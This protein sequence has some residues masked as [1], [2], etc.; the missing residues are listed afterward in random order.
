MRKGGDKPRP[1]T[2]IRRG[3]VYP[4]PCEFEFCKRLFHQNDDLA[5]IGT[6]FQLR[7]VNGELVQPGRRKLPSWSSVVPGEP[8]SIADP[9]IAELQFGSSTARRR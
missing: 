1:Y 3:G 8:H 7:D 2:E 5:A 4:R 9:G 6:G